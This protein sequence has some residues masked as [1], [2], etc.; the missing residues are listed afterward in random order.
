MNRGKIKPISVRIAVH[1]HAT[2]DEEKV[3]KAIRNVLPPN[4]KIKLSRE[5]ISGH[6]GNPII[7][8]EAFIRNKKEAEAIFRWIMSK[9]EGFLYPNWISERFDSST[10]TLYIRLDKQVAYLGNIKLGWG[11]DIIH[12]SFKFPGYFSFSPEELEKEIEMLRKGSD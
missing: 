3:I 2:E 10:K 1:V 11:D 12:I 7:R 8:L 6:Y 9:I 5:V 4:L